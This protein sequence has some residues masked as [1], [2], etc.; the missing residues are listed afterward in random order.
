MDLVL[1]T[2]GRPPG[3]RWGRDRGAGSRQAKRVRAS[4][5]SLLSLLLAGCQAPPPPPPPQ[6]APVVA[7]VKPAG[8]EPVP[9]PVMLP[10]PEPRPA[11]I[12]AIP[13]ERRTEASVAWRRVGATEGELAVYGIEGAAIVAAGERTYVV[14]AGEPMREDA[15]RRRGLSREPVIWAGGRWPDDAWAVTDEG[16][17]ASV[18]GSAPPDAFFVWRWAEDRW[19]RPDRRKIQGEVQELQRA[20]MMSGPGRILLP[21]CSWDERG[22]IDLVAYGTSEEPARPLPFVVRP[23]ACP[24]LFYLPGSEEFFAPNDELSQEKRAM[25]SSRWC[26]KCEAPRQSPLEL[27]RCGAGPVGRVTLG[28]NA[29]QRGDRLVFVHETSHE[30]EGVRGHYLFDDFIVVTMVG[31]E[32]QAELAPPDGKDYPTSLSLAPNGDLWLATSKRLWRRA[33]DGVWAAIGL[34]ADVTEVEQVVALTAE[35]VWLVGETEAGGRVL[36]RV[37]VDV[38][39]PLDLARGKPAR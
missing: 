24:R 31:T 39:A 38:P 33:G 3:G 7:E 10:K 8:P 27:V 11:C 28:L 9:T 12:G 22:V 14:A 19:L 25:R 5:L 6:A 29:A 2:P 34:P 17:D 13:P 21:E 15:G 1:G 23:Q 35:E 20:L 37:A 16:V 32:V 36:D 18:P 26:G 4:S 30:R